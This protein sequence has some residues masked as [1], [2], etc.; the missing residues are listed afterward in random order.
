ME[1]KTLTYTGN[2]PK[3]KEMQ[4]FVGG[5]I[6]VIRISPN[7]QMVVN[8]EGLILKLPLNLIASQLAKRSIVGNVIILID[9]AQMKGKEI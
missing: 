5:Y 1:T 2:T 9:S 8:E 7:K 6:E 3:L 4:D